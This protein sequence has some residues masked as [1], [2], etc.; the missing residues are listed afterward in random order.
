MILRDEKCNQSLYNRLVLT[1]LLFLSLLAAPTPRD[2]LLDVQAQAAFVSEHADGFV[3]IHYTPP[4]PT[5]VDQRFQPKHTALG[6]LVEIEGKARVLA[7]THRVAGVEQA[8]L[9]LADGRRV[10]GS[11][12][13]ADA[14]SAIPFQEFKADKEDALKGVKTL[15]WTDGKPPEEGALL[16]ALEWPLGQQL[17][18]SRA[19]PIL[20]RTTAGVS[21]EPPLERFRYVA[22]G[23]A[24]GLALLN[25]EGLVQ[26]LVFRAVP[27][28]ENKS[29][30]APQNAVL[31]PLK[32]SAQ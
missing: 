27:G 17:P 13:P 25:H 7:P 11:F 24:D 26:C 2:L 29:L 19:Q 15:K 22:L 4:M 31:S 28:I 21:V 32:R 6:A 10:S 18:N 14:S 1:P 16:W 12:N 20:I 23:R 5:E 9:E 30:C 3:R 8:E